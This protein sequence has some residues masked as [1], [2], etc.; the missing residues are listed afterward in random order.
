VQDVGLPFFFLEAKAVVNGT[1][2]GTISTRTI[3]GDRA[4]GEGIIE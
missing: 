4:R 2:A 1:A 3:I